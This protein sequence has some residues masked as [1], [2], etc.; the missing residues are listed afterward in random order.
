MFARVIA[1][2]IAVPEERAEATKQRSR[3][4]IFLTVNEYLQGYRD[5]PRFLSLVEQVGLS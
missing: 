3:D 5:D 2:C 1:D 4:V